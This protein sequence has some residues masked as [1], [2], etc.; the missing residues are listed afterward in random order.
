MQNTSHAVLN[1]TSDLYLSDIYR[2]N[3]PD[4]R[5]VYFGQSAAIY[6][7]QYIDGNQ[8]E[9]VQLVQQF[10]KTD[11]KEIDFNIDKRQYVANLTEL[12]K[13]LDLEMTQIHRY[14]DTQ[15]AC[16]HY[17]SRH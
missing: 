8:F 17:K 14:Q 12:P 4:T 15:V 2:F 7:S 3:S 9:H 13:K 1:V 11:Q 5:V 10:G 6:Y 16:L